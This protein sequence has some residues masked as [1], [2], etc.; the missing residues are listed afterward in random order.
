MSKGKP[1]FP[2]IVR[3]IEDAFLQQVQRS[4][5][6]WVVV[7]DEHGQPQMVIDA[8]G[9]LR[10]ALFGSGDFDPAPFCHRPIIIT[11]EYVPIGDVLCKLRVDAESDEDD[12]IDRDIILLWTSSRRIITGADILGRLLRGIVVHGNEIAICN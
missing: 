12:V 8:D 11:D 10:D 9:F 5:E 2:E 6:K 1:E 3:S 7:I 4:G